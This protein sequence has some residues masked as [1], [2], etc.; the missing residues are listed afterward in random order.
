MPASSLIFVVIIAVWAAF[1]LQHW[2]RR[3]DHVATA[4]SVDRFSE[5]MRVLERRQSLARMDLSRPVPRSYSVSPLRPAHP[6]VVVKRADA[7]QSAPPK[8]RTPARPA[9]P[10][11]VPPRWVA[12]LRG[13]TLLL[14]VAVS[15]A[16]VGLGLSPLLPW[17][18]AAAAPV[19]PLLTVVVLLLLLT[20]PLLMWLTVRLA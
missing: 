20:V 3:R 12:T 13:A 19:L 10:R 11:G 14:A 18:V 17:W 8:R 6:D 15:A 2:I 16:A 7:G 1:L 4:K 5:A 9:P